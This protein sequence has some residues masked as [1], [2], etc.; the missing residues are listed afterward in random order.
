MTHY[1]QDFLDL[2]ITHHALQFGD[3]TLKSGI[4]STVFCNIGM[5]ASGEGLYQLAQCYA[6]MIVS[7]NLAFDMLFG[8]AYKGIPLASVLATILHAE[9]NINKPVAYN[10]KEKKAHGEGGNIIGAPLAGNVLIVDDVITRGT[11]CQEAIQFVKDAGAKT[12][13][14]AVAVDRQEQMEMGQTASEYIAHKHDISVLSITTLH[15]IQQIQAQRAP[16]E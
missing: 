1:E 10:R 3:F 9:Y 5:I 15:A 2:A 12:V 8:P 11:A 14:L 6:A 16:A 4:K 7:H 13:G